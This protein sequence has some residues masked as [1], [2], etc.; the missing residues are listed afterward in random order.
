M[1]AFMFTNLNKYSKY[2]NSKWFII[3]ILLCSILSIVYL[4]LR[5]PA[6]NS[7]V[8]STFDYSTIIDHFNGKLNQGTFLFSEPVP[9]SDNKCTTHG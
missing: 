3:A 6:D 5:H 2:Q 7:S 8:E 1:E 9:N 4:Q